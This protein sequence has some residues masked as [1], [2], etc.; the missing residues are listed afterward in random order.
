MQPNMM[1]PAHRAGITVAIQPG[2]LE[3]QFRAGYVTV[4]RTTAGVSAF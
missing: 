1:F 4:S 3:M 2:A